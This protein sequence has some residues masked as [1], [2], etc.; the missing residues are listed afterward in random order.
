MLSSPKKIIFSLLVGVSLAMAGCGKGGK[1]APAEK[2]DLVC[3]KR[4]DLRLVVATLKRDARETEAALREGA[5]P[6]ASVEGLDPPLVIA[7][8]TDNYDA[9]KLLLDKGANI[10][11]RDG[12]G[13]TALINAC[14]NNNK[15]I[16]ELL[17]ARGADAN[18]PTYPIING[19]K[20]KFTALMIATS[21]G[22]KEIVRSLT[23]AG[24]KE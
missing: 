15:D 1:E 22:N 10:N 12:E 2:S 21:K 20:V 13:S 8:L 11:A 24:A 17:L 4:A 18:V 9:V 14:F 16:V 7:A 6:N 3:L 23:A 19:K 5:D